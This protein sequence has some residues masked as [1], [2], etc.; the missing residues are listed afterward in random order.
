MLNYAVNACHGLSCL[1]RAFLK[2]IN[3]FSRFSSAPLCS[4]CSYTDAHLMVESKSMNE[5]SM[6]CTSS[7]YSRIDLPMSYSFIFTFPMNFMRLSSVLIRLLVSSICL[8]MFLLNCS[9]SFSG[10]VLSMSVTLSFVNLVCNVVPYC[11]VII[12]CF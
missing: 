7:L 5:C 4:N 8:L 9:I 1:L 2:G 12:G 3:L 10:S 11:G 6:F